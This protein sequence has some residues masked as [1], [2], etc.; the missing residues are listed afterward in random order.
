[1]GVPFTVTPSMDGNGDTVYGDFIGGDTE[2]ICI[3]IA[4]EA[5]GVVGLYH[6]KTD[7]VD[8]D[9][10]KS[11]LFTNPFEL[12]GTGWD[13]YSL[14]EPSDRFTHDY[15][16]FIKV[17]EDIKDQGGD[18]NGFIYPVINNS[19]GRIPFIQHTVATIEG[20]TI[21]E[22]EFDDKYDTQITNDGS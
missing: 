2:Y 5:D 19:S 13:D 21:T 22:S 18:F 20:T 4:D 6:G 11:F 17:W 8:G 12:Y 10:N 3:V 7:E 15:E 9:P 16:S 14:K 1:M